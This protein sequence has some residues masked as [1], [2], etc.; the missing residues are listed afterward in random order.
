MTTYRGT[1]DVEPGFYLHT[2]TFRVAMIER[3]GR[4]PGA[5]ADTY[6]RVPIL[7]MLAAAPLLGLVYV[8]FLPFIGFAAVAYLVGGRAVQFAAR[9]AGETGRVRRPAWAPMLAFFT[10]A[11]TMKTDAKDQNTAPTIDAWADDVEK[12]LNDENAGER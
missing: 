9:V 10:R 4:L 12:Q 1:Q 3:Y 5:D 8:I 2:R 6:R 11:K 7:L